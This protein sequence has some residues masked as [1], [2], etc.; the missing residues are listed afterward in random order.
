MHSFIIHVVPFK[1]LS[2]SYSPFLIPNGS[3]LY[4]C[5]WHAC[6]F[7]SRIPFRLL[8]LDRYLLQALWKAKWKGENCFLYES[9]LLLVTHSILSHRVLTLDLTLSRQ[10]F[11]S[12]ICIISEERSFTHDLLSPVHIITVV[13][14]LVFGNYFFFLSSRLAFVLLFCFFFWMPPRIQLLHIVFMSS[15]TLI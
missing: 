2:N 15:S 9:W 14:W 11:I 8:C 12:S 5:K 4:T 7:L 3:K 10:S 6:Y 13:S 1:C